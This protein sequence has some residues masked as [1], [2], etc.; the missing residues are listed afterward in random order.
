VGEGGPWAI[1][2]TAAAADHGTTTV[3][4][5]LAVTLAAEPGSRVL[6][7]DADFARPGAARRLGLS[8]A[9]GLAEVLTRDTPL[10]WV[11]QPTAVP[12]L[13][14]LG[15]GCPTDATAAAL[16]ED[17]PTLVGQLRQWFDWVLIDGGVWGELPERDALCPAF[18]AVYLVTREADRDEPGC[19]TA[20]EQITRHGGLLRGYISTKV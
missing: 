19:G 20:R 4:L 12:R 15:A 16:A 14:V 2:R 6:A 8:D 1:L 10:A 17:F 5:N 9:P 7:V 11:L 18:D 13:Q 3:L